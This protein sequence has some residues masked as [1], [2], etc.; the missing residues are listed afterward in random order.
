MLFDRNV[1]EW[2]DDERGLGLMP[3]AELLAPVSRELCFDKKLN[4][5][6]SNEERGI[7]AP[8]YSATSCTTVRR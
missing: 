6:F 7:F 5:P 2:I 8:R 3:E 4:A 1:A